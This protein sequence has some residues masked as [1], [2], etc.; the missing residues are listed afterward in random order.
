MQTLA[1]LDIF[2]IILY[3]IFILGVAVFASRKS[4]KSTDD[5]FL[6]GR[7]LGWFAIGASLFAS[8]I[9]S[10]H[11][12]GL[13]GAG[14]KGG[15]AVSQFELLASFILLLLGWI[16]VPFYI[17]SGV[18]TMPEF[19]EKRYGRPARN[20]LS[21]ISVVS[22]VITKI[23]ATIF[24]GA[25]V[26][27]GLGLE[28]WTGAVLVVLF[29]GIYTVLG[30]LRAVIYTDTFQLFVILIASAALLYFGLDRVGGY[31]EL[32]ITL[33]PEYFNLWKEINHP[34][35]PWT[36]ILF[37]APIL[38]VWYW[39]TDQFIVQRVLSA[40]NISQARKGTIF[41]GFLKLLPLF[42]FVF[43]G[44]IAKALS[45]KGE[46]VLAQNDQALPVLI[47][48]ILPLG[49]KG[50]V[51]AALLA[52]LMSSLSSVFNSC[53]TLITYDFYKAKYPNTPD[54]KLNRFGQITTIAL[55]GMG[56]LWI[57]LM[58]F[59]SGNLFTYIQ[60]VQAYISPPVACVF[61]LGLFYPKV[62]LKGAMASLWTG[63]VLGVFRL[64]LEI[65]QASLTKGGW[66]KC[67][68]EINFLHFAII[69]F[70]ICLAVL[71]GVSHMT[72]ADNNVDLEHTVYKKETL[73][74]ALSDK[75]D[76]SLSLGLV[77]ALLLLWWIFS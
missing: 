28:F 50:L 46:L 34:E 68:V 2:V 42:I 43:P 70:V 25:V 24:A 27:T 60:S 31:D 53:S 62:N 74:F 40:K 45:L 18:A 12:I 59:V 7:N 35:F 71:L 54:A 14:A 52:A 29:T 21:I 11:L 19:L 3:F 38:G 67:I 75:K 32:K 10:E 26:F 1:S 36:G 37:G 41:A 51:M 56:L 39:C 69:L 4:Q 72:K 61:L 6:A 49:F 22:Y 77:F 76:L 44:M 30:G 48:T 23:S 58:K 65:N 47:N 20:Y 55:V 17:K 33:G 64:M 57:P 73:R 8:N 15:V 9:G 63:F 66:L 16:F 13:A 5:Y